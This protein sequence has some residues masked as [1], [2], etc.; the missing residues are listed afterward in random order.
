MKQLISSF[1]KGSKQGS[2]L[3]NISNQMIVYIIPVCRFI[4]GMRSMDIPDDP[5][6]ILKYIIINY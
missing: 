6:N 3:F 4:D 2:E 1:K 5:L